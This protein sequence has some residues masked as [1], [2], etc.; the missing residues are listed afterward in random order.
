MTDPIDPQPTPPYTPPAAPQTPP[1][2]S[3]QT[4]PPASASSEYAA[5]PAYTAP[6][7][8]PAGKAP[9][10]SIIG[11]SSGILGILG[12]WSGWTLL[13]SIGGV[14]LGHIGQRKE[15]AAKAF[16]I[17]ALITGYL[18]VVV[19]IISLIIQILAF[20]L[21]LNQIPNLEELENLQ[22]Y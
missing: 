15:P 9:V 13:F 11:M 6:P 19:N 18:G 14:V 3:S 12:S 5:P 21:V 16:W 1:P 8:A 17:T 20:V 22:N 7:S 2:A 10:L 4:P